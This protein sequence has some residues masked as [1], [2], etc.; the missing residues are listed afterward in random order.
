M[1]AR[2]TITLLALSSLPAFA[3]PHWIRPDS[4]RTPW[5]QP[6][7]VAHTFQVK[8]EVK[9][10]ALRLVADFCT[11]TV[12]INDRRAGS[13]EAY[14]SLIR[15]DVSDL[16]RKG[17]NRIQLNVEPL[18]GPFAG[19]LQLE[20]NHPDGQTQRIVTDSNWSH[21]EDRGPVNDRY[22]G[23]DSKRVEVDI[24]EDYEQW[25][26]AKTNDA[27]FAKQFQLLPGYEIDLIR[28]AGKDEDSWIAMDFDPQ[29]RLII[30]REKKGLLRLTFKNGKVAKTEVI[31]DDLPE[32]RGILFVHDALYVNSNKHNVRSNPRDRTGGLYRLRDTNGDDHYDEIKL[33]GE[34]TA[35]GGHG[36]ND[37]TLGPDGKIYL[38]GGDS[39]A[40]PKNFTDL[41]PEI[42]NHLPG[43][44]LPHGHVMRTDK[45]GQHWELVCKGLRNPYG[46]AFNPEGESFTFDADAEYDMGSPWYRPT[47]VRQLVQG[48]D[49]HWRRVTDRWPPYYADHADNPPITLE[50]GKSSPTSV[51]FGTKAKFPH[52]Y[53]Q[54][55]F[56][57]DWTYGR[58]MAIHMTPRGAGYQCRTEIFLQG[59]PANVTDLAFGPD[60]AMYFVTGGRGTQSGLYR[61][62]YTG[63]VDEVQ[64]SQQ[65]QARIAFGRESRNRRDAIRSWKTSARRDPNFARSI[66]DRILARLG[67]P[68]P[69]IR[70]ATRREMEHG[71]LIN[72]PDSM[73][74][75]AEANLLI[76]YAHKIPS[77]Y[78]ANIEMGVAS[79]DWQSLGETEK[80]LVLRAAHI[81]HLRREN[82]TRN[83]RLAQH[84]NPFFPDP[85]TK[86]NE[87]LIQYLG[88]FQVP[89]LVPKAIPVLLAAKDQFATTH[90][91]LHLRQQTN[92]W[93]PTL[94]HQY[95]TTL[96]QAADSR[97]GRGFPKFLNKIREDAL[98][99]IPENERAQYA[100]LAKQKDNL[101][102]L[103]K[104]I[105][106]N[107]KFVREWKLTDF[108]AA[109][110]NNHQSD[111]QRGREMY[112]A[113]SC[114]L[115]H[116]HGGSGRVFG[117]DL[118]NAA[119]RFARR[120]LLEAI[121]DPSKVVSE[122]YRN[123]RLL[124]KN[125]DDHTGRIAYAGDY[126]KSKLR[127]HTNPLRP[128]EFV[129]VDKID[130][131]DKRLSEISSMPEGLLNSLSKQE[132]LDLLAYI[133]TG[134]K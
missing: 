2:L 93:T 77:A 35:T 6:R 14:G 121:L 98:K 30:A 91:L 112:T 3:Q 72:K 100:A 116:Q 113:A 73:T 101:A 128:N 59:R 99:T 107:R 61:V 117:P 102:E 49:Y 92:A 43:D 51:L 69:W 114:I 134:A 88:L 65:E 111:L 122:K 46:I 37:L 19:A 132:I 106:T 36:R 44:D 27:T 95:F 4:P 15:I 90:Y 120:D 97:A 9:S 115:C 39:V 66:P 31:N 11:A 110:L 22:W 55:L 96:R 52:A 20:I 94:R 64:L 70:Y 57:L 17:E 32:I 129:E 127:L 12:S 76:A 124:M 130:I 119:S 10:A 29:G 123:V 75:L 133:E 80:L 104:T 5:I 68:D 86:V 26:R 71:L 109:D 21:C 82:N 54:A 8:T 42:P 38:I 45:D 118:S 67:D 60:G 89:N 83:P 53:Q 87:A 56:I 50:I 23:F 126:R 63:P 105:P 41:T 28:N 1:F 7:E 125:G 18:N 24:F 13:A 34:R 81:C 33:L 78:L 79:I 84:L 48:A 74:R 108:T 47:H 85:S 25:R 40:K 131:T 58:I 62:H 103:I 16:I